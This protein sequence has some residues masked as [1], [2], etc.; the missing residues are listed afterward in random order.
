MCRGIL[1]VKFK[2]GWI[3]KWLKYGLHGQKMVLTWPLKFVL[4]ESQSLCPGMFHAKFQ[5]TGCFL[6]TPFLE[7]AKILPF[8]AK[9]WSSHGP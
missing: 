6:Y 4:P 8:M 7:M 2:N 1:H 3:Y 5:I 9:T